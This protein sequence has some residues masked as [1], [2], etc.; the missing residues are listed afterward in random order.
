MKGEII[1][2]AFPVLI[3]P[4]L[5]YMNTNFSMIVD[6]QARTSS[7]FWQLMQ[8]EMTPTPLLCSFI[9]TGAKYD[10]FKINILF[11]FLRINIQSS[12]PARLLFLLI[13]SSSQQSRMIVLIFCFFNICNIVILTSESS[14]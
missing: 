5:E 4:T 13:I 3:L 1:F 11:Y 8:F 12:S 7:K 9:D 6:C 10:L 2:F 14:S